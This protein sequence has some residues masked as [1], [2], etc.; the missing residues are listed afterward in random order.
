M[1]L[2]DEMAMVKN[3]LAWLYVFVLQE[4]VSCVGRFDRKVLNGSFIRKR[5]LKCL[6]EAELFSWTDGR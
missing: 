6:V 1:T 5:S 4:M 2:R 3:V